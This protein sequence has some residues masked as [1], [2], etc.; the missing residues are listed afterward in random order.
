MRKGKTPD[1]DE[2][3]LKRYMALSPEE[4][5]KGLEEMTAFLAAVTPRRVKRIQEELEKRGW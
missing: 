2:D 4:K 3:Q 1:F 5:L